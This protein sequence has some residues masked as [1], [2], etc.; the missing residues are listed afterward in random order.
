MSDINPFKNEP[1]LEEFMFGVPDD[2]TI[3]RTEEKPVS[4]PIEYGERQ[5]ISGEIV[6]LS[7]G[8]AIAYLAQAMMHRWNKYRKE[9][10]I[11]DTVSFPDWTLEWR[12]V[13]KEEDNDEAPV[14]DMP[15]GA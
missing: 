11:P 5:Y 3:W 12:L 9:N 4:D 1:T 15:G 2:P 13:I 7:N 14:G 10:G 8:N 6:A